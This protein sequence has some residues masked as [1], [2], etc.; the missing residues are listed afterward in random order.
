MAVLTR[1]TNICVS[2]DS[3]KHHALDVLN[4]TNAPSSS[5]LDRLSQALKVNVKEDIF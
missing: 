4:H 3:E 2:N 1:T 5:V